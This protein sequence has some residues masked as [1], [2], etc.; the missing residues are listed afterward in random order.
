MEHH[1]LSQTKAFS[2]SKIAWGRACC[3]G[4]GRCGDMATVRIGEG[5]PAGSLNNDEV[6]N[7]YL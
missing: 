6:S 5:V 3:D 2:S 4:N 7:K 1:L